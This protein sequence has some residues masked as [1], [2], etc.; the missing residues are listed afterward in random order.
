MSQLPYFLKKMAR[1][2]GSTNGDTASPTHRIAVDEIESPQHIDSSETNKAAREAGV[3]AGYSTIVSLE[4]KPLI[5]IPDNGAG[6]NSGFASA[7]KLRLDRRMPIISNDV[8]PS[9]VEHY[10]SLRTKI[11]QQQTSKPFRTLVV[12][13]PAPGEG[14]TLTVLNLGWSFAMLPSFRILLVD[15]DLRRGSLGA[16]LGVDK[17][18]GLSN[19]IEGSAKLEE[20]VLQCED[21]PLHFIGR[22]DSKIS[23]SEL[24]QSCELKTRFHELAEHFSLVLVDSPPANLIS[25]VQLLAAGCDAVLLLARAFSTTRKTFEKAVHDVSSFRVIGSVLNGATRTNRYRYYRGYY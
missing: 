8:D 22:G 2:P 19:F 21:V 17:H 9:I 7:G 15:G 11:L 18:P 25:D 1:F 24:L 23:P 6:Q 12:T 3:R 20:V 5:S 13:S 10:R 14:K 4:Q 16:S